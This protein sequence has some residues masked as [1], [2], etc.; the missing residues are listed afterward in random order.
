[1]RLRVA[2]GAGCSLDGY[3][4]RYV[5][6][7]RAGGLLF[8]GRLRLDI[9]RTGKGDVG[10]VGAGHLTFGAWAEAWVSCLDVV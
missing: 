9:D 3:K 2:F 6:S 4:V 8:V 7:V 10:G 5:R 1:M